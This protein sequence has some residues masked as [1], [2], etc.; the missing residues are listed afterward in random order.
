MDGYRAP[1]NG[2]GAPSIGATTIGPDEHRRDPLGA[3][4]CGRRGRECRGPGRLA[5]CGLA[6]CGLALL[7]A[8]CATAARAAADGPTAAGA[9]PTSWVRLYEGLIGGEPALLTVNFNWDPAAPNT[10]W[11]SFFFRGHRQVFSLRPAPRGTAGASAEAAPGADASRTAHWLVACDPNPLAGEERAPG[12]CAG[13]WDVVVEDR[14]LSGSW[15]GDGEV[16]ERHI[17]LGRLAATSSTAPDDFNARLIANERRIV[18]DHAARFG[19]EWQTRRQT[20]REGLQFTT[21]IRLLR[22]PNAAARAR[23]NAWLAR[24]I[25]PPARAE[26]CAI[27]EC[28]SG[29]FD[30]VRYADGR[31]LA[32]GLESY[33]E[34]G[35]HPSNE[36]RAITFDL[37]TGNEVRWPELLRFEEAQALDRTLDLTR[38]DLLA[39]QFLLALTESKETRRNDCM[40][41]VVEHYECKGLWCERRPGLQEATS[42]WSVYPMESGLAVTTDVFNEP[43]RGCRGVPAIVPWD[44]VRPTLKAPLALP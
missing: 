11:G 29:N 23:I 35:V 8:A 12:P 33:W 1:S 14:G 44:S 34:G 32:I 40:A 16:G 17:D 28:I 43:Q 36:F 19:V 6:R 3:R 10:L 4:D 15:R 38:K 25:S 27:G 20:S 5:R 24:N 22:S 41:A 7:L 30:D 21:G 37:Q 18:R 42:T 2:C 9:N 39:A 13:A 26:E 31:W